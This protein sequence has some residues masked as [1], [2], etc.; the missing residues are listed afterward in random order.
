VPAEEP[1]DEPRWAYDLLARV[2]DDDMG[3]NVAGHDVDFYVRAALSA[4]DSALELGCGTGRITLPLVRAGLSVTGVDRSRPMLQ[5][6]EKKTKT[7]LSSTERERL[8]IEPMD[9]RELALDAR[10]DSVLCPYS[11]FT[12]L[13]SAGDRRRALERIHAHLGRGGNFV[14]DVF[15]PDPEIHARATQEPIVDYQRQ[16]PDGTWL[17]RSRTLHIDVEPR[18]NVIE[19][20]YRLL[21]PDRRELERFTTTSRIR[22]W[23]PEE[24]ERELQTHAFEVLER[25]LDFGHAEPGARPKMA[26]FRCRPR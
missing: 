18:V 13:V 6:L 4:G 26:A 14:L 22:C 23:Q 21:S 24:L 7:E 5:V 17:E 25:S 3:R 19:R 9:M 1:D 10:F 8:R 16:R 12:Y 20:H 15:V 2:Y 11:A